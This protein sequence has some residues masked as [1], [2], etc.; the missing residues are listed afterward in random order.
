[1]RL[2]STARGAALRAMARPRR[3]WSASWFGRHTAASGVRVI[4]KPL[5]KACLNSA[6]WRMRT[7]RCSC[8]P[9]CI[10]PGLT[11]N[12]ASSLRDETGAALG[13]TTRQHQTTTNRGHTGAETVGALAPQG[14]RLERTFHDCLLERDKRELFYRSNAPSSN[15]GPARALGKVPQTIV[16]P[17]PQP[18]LHAGF[19]ALPGIIGCD[20]RLSAIVVDGAT[21]ACG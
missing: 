4:L 9:F 20:T 1:M 5:A 17:S 11:L 2:R 19:D 15:S 21:S 8:A 12:S 3:G 6:G 16:Q 13:A 14:V 10:S 18:P 7:R